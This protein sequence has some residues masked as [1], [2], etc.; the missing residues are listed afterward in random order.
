MIFAKAPV[1]GNVKTRLIPHYGETYATELQRAMLWHNLSILSE[2]NL[3]PLEL[4][5]APD[6][7]DPFFVTCR[8]S[9]KLTL[10]VQ[11]GESLGDK[12]DDAFTQLLTEAESALVIGADCPTLQKKDYVMA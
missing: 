8:A 10:R 11:R 9:F 12:M 7:V 3:C 1:L 5:C 2:A 4:W 6:A